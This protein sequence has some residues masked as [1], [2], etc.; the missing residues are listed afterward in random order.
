MSA[1]PEQLTDN[2]WRWTARHPEWH[3]GE[4]GSE[5]ACFALKAGD[6]AILIDPLLPPAPDAVLEMIDGI[7]ADRLAMLISVP[8]HVRS[9]EEIW[10][11]YRKDADTAIWGHAAS[12][13]RLTDRKA[14]KEIQP[15][16]SDLP[17]GITAHAIGKPKRH[18][19]PFHVPS[20]DALVFG[21][22]VAEVDGDLVVWSNEPLDAKV[23][24]F[25]RERFNPT[26]EPLLGLDFER[27]LVTH[28][29]PVMKDGRKELEK[30]LGSKP[31][32]RA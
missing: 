26:L 4:F 16:N 31:W 12:A 14:F 24:R 7:V 1:T 13:K 19:M 6:D 28:G 25:Y 23:E 27:V 8:Y 9:S 18:E 10:H 21:D 32:Y 5:V 22:S 17:A 15:G 2:L 30:A 3:P 20:H 11:R 29:Q